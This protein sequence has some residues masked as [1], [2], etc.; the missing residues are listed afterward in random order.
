MPQRSAPE[1]PRPRAALALL[2]CAALSL[3]GL[4]QA[5]TMYEFNATEL[6]WVA[7]LV[8]EAVVEAATPE[9]LE[10]SQLL[11]TVT[12]LRLVRVYKGDGV[13][14]DRVTLPLVGGAL[15]GEET[16]MP[17]AARFT[18]GERVLVFLERWSEGWRPVGMSQGAW[19][20]VAEPGSGR[21]VL[22]KV[23]RDYGLREFDEALV[24]LPPPALRKYA[25]GYLQQLQADLAEGTVP[26]YD[27]IPGL[28]PHKDRAFKK[29]ALAA[30][31]WIDPR[32]FAPG[33]AAELER[34]M[35]GE[36][37]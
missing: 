20:I 17:A 6:G 13:E 27:S 14:G 34:E 5:T 33:E 26:A 24:Q 32:Y 9:H 11:R 16:T 23:H 3:P 36:R 22:V 4:A 10:G 15:D 35:E 30:G 2:F 18:P 25:D 8:A 29:E 21:D 37:R 28:P 12:D 31:Q 19:T 7:D 1:V